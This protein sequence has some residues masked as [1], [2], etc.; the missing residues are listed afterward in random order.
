MEATLVPIVLFAAI[1]VIV[2]AALY[3]NHKNKAKMQDTLQLSIEK[4]Q[5]LSPD[6]IKAMLKDNPFNDLKKGIVLISIGL[7]V[8]VF[9]LFDATEQDFEMVGIGLIPVIIGLGYV[10]IWKLRPKFEDQ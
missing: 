1:A 2:V 6:V 5:E 8:A 3:I 9:S 10:L 7:A 4:G